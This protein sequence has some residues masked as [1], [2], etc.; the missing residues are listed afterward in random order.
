MF[1]LLV[2][3]ALPVEPE[4]L[5]LG[6]RSLEPKLLRS[7]TLAKGVL[8]SEI[9]AVTEGEISLEPKAGEELCPEKRFMSSQSILSMLCEQ[10]ELLVFDDLL[11]L[12]ER[13]A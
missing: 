1:G 2:G 11:W 12:E 6:G 10:P 8:K 13:E 4:V 9:S 5:V 3:Q 7:L